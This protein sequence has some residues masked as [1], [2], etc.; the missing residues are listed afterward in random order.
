MMTYACA[1]NLVGVVLLIL[2]IF[3]FKSG[4]I[5]LLDHELYSPWCQKI[6]SVKN[7]SCKQRLMK[8]CMCTSTKFG[9]HCLSSFGAFKQ[10]NFPFWTIDYTCTDKVLTVRTI[11]ASAPLNCPFN[12]PMHT[13]DHLK[14]MLFMLYGIKWWNCNAAL[15]LI[16]CCI[17]ISTTPFVPILYSNPCM[18]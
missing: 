14:R 1:P 18:F 3:S 16:S 7:N 17:T 15:G 9:G 10:P 4:Q 11:V 8:I 13:I 12:M 5:F 2:E 6:E